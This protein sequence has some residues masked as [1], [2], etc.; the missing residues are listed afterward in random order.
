MA[1]ASDLLILPF[2]HPHSLQSCA[3][4]SCRVTTH[5][6]K[7]SDYCLTILHNQQKHQDTNT[8]HACHDL[9]Y[10]QILRKCLGVVSGSVPGE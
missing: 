4:L 3:L 2:C 10:Q 5:K 9:Q 7:L 8:L 6:T 1:V